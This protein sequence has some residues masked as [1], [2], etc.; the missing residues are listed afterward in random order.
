MRGLAR[1]VEAAVGFSAGA[2]GRG[3]AYVRID[4]PNRER[5]GRIGFKV[6][7]AATLQTTQYAALTAVARAL[8]RRGVRHVRFVVGDPQFADEITGARAI[9]QA[10]AIPYVRLRC[11]LNSLMKFSVRIGEVDDLTQRARAEAA[12]NVAA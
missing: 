10:L 4:A 6:A 5:I 11:A 1:V 7:M 2:D 3:I 8:H 9:E 12:L